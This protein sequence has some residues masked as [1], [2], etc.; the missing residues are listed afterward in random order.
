M[1]TTSCIQ[2]LLRSREQAK[3]EEQRATHQK[4]NSQLDDDAACILGQK[5]EEN[6]TEQHS[7]PDA[8]QPTKLMLE[9]SPGYELTA[10]FAGRTLQ[11]LPAEAALAGRT[12][13]TWQ[14]AAFRLAA[15]L[16]HT[17]LLQKVHHAYDN[18]IL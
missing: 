18:A 5:E 9:G 16:G 17:S 7:K 10:N 4:Q 8:H 15:T 11:M 2:I 6:A 13:C 14:R 1:K 12:N 3:P